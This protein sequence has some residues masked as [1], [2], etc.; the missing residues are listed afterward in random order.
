MIV[1]PAI[2]LMGGKAVRL[3]KGDYSRKTVYNEDPVSQAREFRDAGAEWLHLVD[4]DGAKSGTEENAEVIE[5]IVK[6]TSLNVEVGGGIRS[7]DT[8]HRYL[9]LG[10]RRVI[11]GTIAIE[12]P[13]F[14]KAAIERYG[15]HI[16]VGVDV[17]EGEVRTRGWTKGSGR[18]IYDFMNEL[19]DK[20]VKTVICTDISRDGMMEGTNVSLYKKLSEEF[21]TIDII[22]SGGVSSM[23]DILRLKKD[24]I[25]GAIIGKALY[26]GAIDLHEAIKVAGEEEDDN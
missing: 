13:E 2:D 8:I 19:T 17:L 20:G 12:D 21:R 16:A 7:M 1:L 3:I 15:E 14:L 24:G 11:L 22:A 4:L 10:V 26:T 18:D 25:K 23:E 9:A 5:K 6:E